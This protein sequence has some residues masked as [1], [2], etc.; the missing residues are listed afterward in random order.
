MTDKNKDVSR[1]EDIRLQ[2]IIGITIF[3]LVA[4]RL[5]TKDINR[6]PIVNNFYIIDDKIIPFRFR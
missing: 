4:V 6:R 1:K 3:T 5:M 2:T